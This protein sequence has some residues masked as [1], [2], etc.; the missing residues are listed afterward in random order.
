MAHAQGSFLIFHEAPIVLRTVIRI[1]S[2]GLDDGVRVV[3]LEED[4]RNANL[5]ALCGRLL[6]FR[7]SNWLLRWEEWTVAKLIMKV[8]NGGLETDKRLRL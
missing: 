8:L 7:W 4:L 2:A 3:A 5:T 6:Y 1:R